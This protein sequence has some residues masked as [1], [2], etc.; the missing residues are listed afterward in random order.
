MAYYLFRIYDTLVTKIMFGSISSSNIHGEIKYI[1]QARKR[2]FLR[3]E[4]RFQVKRLQKS[5]E[6]C[7]RSNTSDFSVQGVKKLFAMA[8]RGESTP[9]N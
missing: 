9:T 3:I 5:T 4:L 2:I 1:A 7:Y 8:F 6:F